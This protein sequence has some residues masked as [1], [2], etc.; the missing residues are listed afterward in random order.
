MPARNNSEFNERVVKLWAENLSMD[1]L[2]LELKKIKMSTFTE[3][4]T[5]EAARRLKLLKPLMDV[6]DEYE[7]ASKA[8]KHLGSYG[9]KVEQTARSVAKA[10]E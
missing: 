9:I 2:I 7:E 8:R 1:I 4:L 10:L 5:N 3:A 6:V